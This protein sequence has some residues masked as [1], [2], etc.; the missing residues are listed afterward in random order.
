MTSTRTTT[1][2]STPS[3]RRAP[4]RPAA[5]ALALAVLASL[6]VGAPAA[7][8]SGGAEPAWLRPAHL[9]PDLGAMDIRLSPFTDEGGTTPAEDKPL[10]E[11]TAAYGA[12][13]Q[14]G[15]VP[16]GSYAVSVRPAGTPVSEPALLSLTIDLEPGAAYTVA[17]LGTKDAPRLERLVDDL[18]PPAQGTAKVRLLPAS[19]AAPTVDVQAEGGPVLA[20]GAALGQP[21]SYAAAPAGSWTISARGASASGSTALT[22][23]PGTVYTLLVLDSS[24]GSL[25][26]QPV[27]D[28]VGMGTAPVGG[29]ATGF[30]GLA[31]DAAPSTAPAVVLAATAALG[32]LLLTLAALRGRGV[33]PAAALRGRRPAG[34]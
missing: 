25:A 15:P 8:A 4:A 17:G 24:G 11:T 18:T 22:L 21:T 10:L 30:G 12:V 19:L 1:S 33:A 16:A 6:L 2:P 23:D 28:A 14:Y 20:Q 13:G 3:P 26:V 9:V 29:A 27:V 34:R 32:L 31:D 7:S 5:L